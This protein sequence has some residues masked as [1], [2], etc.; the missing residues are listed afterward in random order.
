MFVLFARLGFSESLLG[1]PARPTAFNSLLTSLE[2]V[3]EFY[4]YKLAK[5]LF[6]GGWSEPYWDEF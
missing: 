4:F 2:P 5:K 6:F 3:I 1:D